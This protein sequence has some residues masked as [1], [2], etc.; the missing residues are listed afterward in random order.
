MFRITI[1]KGK[2]ISIRKRKMI[3]Q[4]EFS[5]FPVQIALG[6]SAYERLL[7]LCVPYL[8]IDNTLKKIQGENLENVVV[9]FFLDI[10]YY[11]IYKGM[12]HF[13]NLMVIYIL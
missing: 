12:Y 5:S 9:R 11:N 1:K 8:C 13:I 7:F 6:N 3:E 10:I 2:Q 4:R